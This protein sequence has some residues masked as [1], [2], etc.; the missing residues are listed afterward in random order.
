MTRA[1]P[2]FL[3]VFLAPV[4]IPLTIGAASIGVS[5]VLWWN[6]QIIDWLDEQ[7][8]GRRPDQS[9][10]AQ[11]KKLLRICMPILFLVIGTGVILQGLGAG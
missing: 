5:F 7:T 4:I 6:P 2:F 8:N 1:Q 11:R 3:F 10:A 9:Q